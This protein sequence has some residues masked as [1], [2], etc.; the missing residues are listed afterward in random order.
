M[1]VLRFGSGVGPKVFVVGGD[2]ST[3]LMFHQED[4]TNV[5]DPQDA[6]FICLTGGPDVSPSL[7]GEANTGL[8]FCNPTRDDVEVGLYKAYKDKAWLGICRGG[9]LLNVLNDGKMHQDIGQHSGKRKVITTA[10]AIN[11]HEDHHQG[12]IPAVGAEIIGMDAEDQNY[13]VVY[14]DHSSCLCFQAHPEWGDNT[15]KEYFFGL[16]ASKYF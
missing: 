16:I 9:Q 1:K 10:G 13:E 14:Y 8:S 4:W 11:L 7:Y 15:T 3:R 5:F 2:A 12:M 6:D